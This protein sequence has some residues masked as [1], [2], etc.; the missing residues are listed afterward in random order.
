MH[1]DWKLGSLGLAKYANEVFVKIS[2]LGL[3]RS[4]GIHD[5]V[6]DAL[7]KLKSLE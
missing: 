5:A 6:I 4:T 1:L 7:G 3:R 2:E